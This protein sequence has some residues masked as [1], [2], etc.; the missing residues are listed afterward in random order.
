MQPAAYILSLYSAGTGLPVSTLGTLFGVSTGDLINQEGLGEISAILAGTQATPISD[1][2][3][4]TVAEQATVKATVASYNQVIAAAAAS[5]NATL[6]DINS[7]F[8]S[9]TANGVA[10]GG[11]TGT[12]SFLGG[13]FSLDGIHP[14]NTG[15]ATLANKFIDTMNASI[16]TAIPDANLTAIAATDPLWPPNISHMG[17]V[18]RFPMTMPSIPG[19][20]DLYLPAIQRQQSS[21][22]TR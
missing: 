5:A 18:T 22:V 15:Y 1:A 19:I 14:T 11:V 6:V 4:L 21:L 3:V 17:S 20:D 12:T 8:A 2:G 9:I 7:L 10:A 13:M 16:G